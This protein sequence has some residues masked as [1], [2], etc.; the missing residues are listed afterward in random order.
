[1]AALASRNERTSSG[2]KFENWERDVK[3]KGE[4]AGSDPAPPLRPLMMNHCRWLTG[5]HVIHWLISQQS[6][7]CYQ[8]AQLLAH[9]S[10]ELPDLYSNARIKLIGN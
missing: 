7:K 9:Y 3:W 1:M 4:G 6:D 8:L 5:Q 2:P 10:F